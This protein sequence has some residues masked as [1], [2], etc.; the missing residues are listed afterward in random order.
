MKFRHFFLTDPMRSAHQ[1]SPLANILRY[2]SSVTAIDRCIAFLKTKSLMELQ[3]TNTIF[4]EK[5]PQ[6]FKEFQEIT[7]VF[8]LKITDDDSAE[9]IINFKCQIHTFHETKPN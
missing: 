4:F 6:K 5:I 3:S 7:E 8:Q 1:R 2:V 9:S